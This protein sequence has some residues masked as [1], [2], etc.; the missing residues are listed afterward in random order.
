MPCFPAG[1][2][3]AIYSPLLTDEGVDGVEHLTLGRGDA[4]DLVE[5]LRS[6]VEDHAIHTMH[7]LVELGVEV[8][9][10]DYLGTPPIRSLHNGL[11]LHVPGWRMRIQ[12]PWPPI[13][14]VFPTTYLKIKFTPAN[15]DLANWE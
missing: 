10:L 3:R 6:R 1:E 2:N 12:E 15:W 8:G 7:P 9:L 4:P 14:V 11:L 13:R 5:Q